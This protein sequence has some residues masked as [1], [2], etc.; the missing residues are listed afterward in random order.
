MNHDAPNAIRRILCIVAVT[1]AAFACIG[2]SPD[3]A[4]LGDTCETTADCA[5]ERALL[6]DDGYCFRVSCA[7]DETCEEGTVCIDELCRAPECTADDQCDESSLCLSNECIEDGCRTKG[8]CPDGQ[9]C[10]GE[11]MTCRPPPDV[12]A[13]DSDCAAGF[14]CW[15][16]TGECLTI[17]EEQGDCEVGHYC[18]ESGR[19]RP[20]CTR[21]TDC[22]SDET[23][24][25]G[26]CE[27][28]PNCSSADPCSGRLRYR[29]PLTCDCVACLIDD[30]CDVA[31]GETCTEARTCLFCQLPADN[32]DCA[33]RELFEQQGCCVECLADSDCGSDEPYCVRGQCARTPA[34]EC[35]ADTDC[36]TDQIC[37]R[38]TCEP[39]ASFASCDVQADCPDTEAC[40]ADGR[41]HAEADSCGGCEEGTR[42]IE[43][44]T[45]SICAGC[46]DDCSSQNCRDGR[47]CVV[48]DG[49][50]DG[51]CIEAALAEQ[52]SG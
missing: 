29:D 1:A 35:I 30:H 28:L 15:P 39:A 51:S 25:G 31:A 36:G 23:C 43:S 20:N 47:V 26:R 45:G 27:P 9:V 21:D 44:A 8:G 40:F 49:S 33:S 11:P 41:C 37:D 17:C 10:R 34:E 46:Q 19:C 52:C 13:S 7:T 3:E 38:G 5:P 32:V 22:L 16:P 42:C 14:S 24:E 4:K 2:C 18:G 50:D 6:C 12:C 48:P